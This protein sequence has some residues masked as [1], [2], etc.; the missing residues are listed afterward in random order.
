M[1]NIQTSAETRAVFDHDDRRAHWERPELR[2]LVTS[3]AE[4]G[5]QSNQNDKGKFNAS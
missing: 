1:E 2:R 4:T 5:V 3:D